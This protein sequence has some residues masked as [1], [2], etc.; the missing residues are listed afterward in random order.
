MNSLWM[1]ESSPIS[2]TYFSRLRCT[3]R[4]AALTLQ[5]LSQ[6]LQKANFLD[7]SG[8]LLLA[9]CDRTVLNKQL[10]VAPEGEHVECGASLNTKPNEINANK[11]NWWSYGP[12][13]G[14]DYKD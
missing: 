5:L 8:L 10:L 9:N 7:N 6:Y 11:M 12:W 3:V 14:G 4:W 2:A 1:A 13:P